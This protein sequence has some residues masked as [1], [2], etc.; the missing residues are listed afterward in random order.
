[1][2]Y[3]GKHAKKSK[4]KV[5]SLLLVIGIALVCLVGG[6][7][8]RYIHSEDYRG[9]QVGAKDFYFGI[10]VLTTGDSDENRVLEREFGLYGSDQTQF[11]FSVQNFFDSLRVNQEDIS[12]TISCAGAVLKHDSGTVSSGSEFTLTAGSQQSH[13]FWI[14]M[15]DPNDGDT[16]TV[17]VSSSSPYRK[18]MTLRVIAHPQSY[19]VLYRIEDAPGR[20]YAKLVVMAGIAVEAQTLDIDWS[21]VNTPEAGNVLQIDT[22]N[23]Y[24][25]T[26]DDLD[27]DGQNTDLSA[28]GSYLSSATNTVK[29]K[30]NGSIAVYF[31]KTDTAADYSQ[32]DTPVELSNGV[33]SIII[34]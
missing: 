22:T 24:I 27:L 25:I 3:C 17:T 11:H 5:M 14:E 1:M 26:A 6:I 12:Y 2:R 33:Y 31:F 18:E 7:A 23:T 28:T 30:E 4:G 19:P 16:A 10:D 20:N 8:A 34:D 9:N 13:A 32:E 21:A 29:I 15:T